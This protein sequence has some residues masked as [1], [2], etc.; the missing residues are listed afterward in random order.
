LVSRLEK[1]KK[2]DYAIK[3]F[4]ILGVPL[5]VVG[6]GA[7][8]QYLKRIAK[9]NVTFM[10]LIDDKSL[11]KAYSKTKAVVFTPHLEYGLIPLEATASGAPV[12]AFGLGGITETMVNYNPMMHLSNR[13]A[14]AVFF[15]KQTE[16]ALIKAVKS[17]EELEFDSEKLV[18]YAR[19]FDV[20]I[21]RKKI[22]EYVT[23]IAVR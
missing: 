8:E 12:I 21:F 20:D 15:Y 23:R 13:T 11:Q 16:E 5:R 7:E 17:F 6:T 2:L 19:Q 3:A 14:T 10:G 9:S 1:W 18:E 4:N 22:R